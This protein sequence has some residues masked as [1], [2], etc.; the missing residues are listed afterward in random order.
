MFVWGSILAWLVV[1]V[2]TSNVTF[3]YTLGLVPSYG[4]SNEVLA[5]GG[6]WFYCILATAV[7]L[8]PV[9]VIETLSVEL[10]PHLLDDVRLLQTIQWK[11]GVREKLKKLYKAPEAP[12]E[13]EAEPEPEPESR[14]ES[15][16]ETPLLTPSRTLRSV[17]SSYAFSHQPGFAELILSGRWMG[18]REDQVRRE[19]M[20]RSMTWTGE[21]PARPPML[22]EIPRDKSVPE[23]FPEKPN[24]LTIR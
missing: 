22:K 11:D 17:R 3:L 24:P 18:A 19:R 2:F 23:E 21:E 9:I 4:V 13:P 16:L 14:P 5:T 12:H 20:Q 7:A 6:F 15:R 10:N 1:T 8:L